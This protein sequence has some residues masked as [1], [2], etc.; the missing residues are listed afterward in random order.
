MR[1]KELLQQL[2]CNCANDV[3]RVRNTLEVF[4][5][6]F[7]KLSSFNPF[8]LSFLP[9]FFPFPLFRSSQLGSKKPPRTS[10]SEIK[11]RSELAHP[12][13]SWRNDSRTPDTESLTKHLWDG[14]QYS[15]STSSEEDRLE[16]SPSLHVL[17][18]F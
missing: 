17:S 13:R 7:S 1:D 15:K 18:G 5:K 3:T 16:F 14:V 8:S 2:F 4:L 11:R 9:S 6:I 12:L 10:H